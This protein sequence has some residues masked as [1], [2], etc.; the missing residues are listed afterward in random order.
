[1]D[2]TKPSKEAVQAWMAAR[3]AERSA[4][5]SPERIREQL[6]WRM[7]QPYRGPASR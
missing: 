6:G 4:P 1:M 2:I 5:P 7:T 3:Q